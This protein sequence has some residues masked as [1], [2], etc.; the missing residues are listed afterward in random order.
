MKGLDWFIGEFRQQAELFHCDTMPDDLE[1]V[2]RE[3]PPGVRE[4][5]AS[6]DQMGLPACLEGAELDTCQDWMKCKFLPECAR[7][8][9]GRLVAGWSWVESEKRGAA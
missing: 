6:L 1:R 2:F 4:H 5:Y 9:V 7:G 3:C 8:Y